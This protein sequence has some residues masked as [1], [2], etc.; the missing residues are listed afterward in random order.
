MMSPKYFEFGCISHLAQ[1]YLKL[2]TGLFVW[3][4]GWFTRKWVHTFEVCLFLKP[5]GSDKVDLDNG[6]TTWQKKSGFS[7]SSEKADCFLRFPTMAVSVIV[8]SCIP[9]LCRLHSR[10]WRPRRHL[11]ADLSACGFNSYSLVGVFIQWDSEGSCSFPH[12]PFLSW[13][14]DTG[15]QDYV[16]GQ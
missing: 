8:P 3:P 13:N 4:H 11:I 10:R 6:V 7:V 1:A 5:G 9:W 15:H 12:L 14:Q 2:S 16:S